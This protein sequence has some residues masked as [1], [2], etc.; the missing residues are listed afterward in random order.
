MPNVMDA[1]PKPQGKNIMSASATQGGHKERQK[2]HKTTILHNRISNYSTKILYRNVITS[3]AGA[4]AKYCDEHVYVCVCVCLSVCLSVCLFVS[5]SRQPHARS[6]HTSITTEMVS[7][8]LRP[9]SNQTFKLHC[10]FLK[11]T[12]M[13]HTITSTHINR[14][15]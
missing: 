13:F 14:F 8:Y 1:L 10:V 9:V 5:I 15:W 12:L 4:V 6:L 11:T 3:P 7:W 2:A